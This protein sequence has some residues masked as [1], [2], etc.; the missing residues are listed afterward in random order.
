MGEN[1]DASAN[2]GTLAARG[3]VQQRSSV[4]TDALAA[5]VFGEFEFLRQ[6]PRQSGPVCHRR[7]AQPCSHALQG[8]AQIHG[9][10]PRGS[11]RFHRAVEARVIGCGRQRNREASG[12]GET[13]QRCTPHQHRADRVGARLET[14]QFNPQ[15]LQWQSCLVQHI[16]AALL[17]E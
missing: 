14:A 1:V 13:D 5:T 17:R 3:S 12:R 7:N 2:A 4:F 6:S 8:P 9:R 16:D 15:V 11:E 10:R